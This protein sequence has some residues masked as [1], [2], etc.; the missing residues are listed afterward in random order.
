MAIYKSE[1]NAA[2]A[3]ELI[4][5]MNEILAKMKQISQSGDLSGFVELEERHHAIKVRLGQLDES[6]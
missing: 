5:E 6:D 4:A 1:A 3:K 2:E